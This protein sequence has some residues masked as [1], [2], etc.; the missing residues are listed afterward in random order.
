LLFSLTYASNPNLQWFGFAIVGDP[1]E[2]SPWTNLFIGSDEPSLAK[3]AELKISSL[4]PVETLFW[5]KNSEGRRTLKADWQNQWDSSK[6]FINGLIAKQHII[7]F[8]L[9]DEAV[10]SG[11]SFSELE[12]IANFVK[13]EYPNETLFYVESA[14]V[15]VQDKNSFDESVDYPYVP[16]AF[17]WFA[18]DAYPN[19]AS[20]ERVKQAY[21]EDI[22]PRMNLTRQHAFL[23]PPAY[24]TTGD[25]MISCGALD[26]T[27]VMIAWAKGFLEWAQS[28]TRISGMM[29]WY[30]QST[31]EPHFEIGARDMPAV[32]A[33]YRRVGNAIV[34]SSPQLFVNI[35][36][37]CAVLC[38]VVF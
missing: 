3:A 29:A 18:A 28:D 24:D 9:V 14:V 36:L 13:N 37:Y 6:P 26:C 32:A 17:D 25:K 8:Y 21:D 12:A 34:N 7:G 11:V 38:A 35:L 4:L 10:W 20:I 1:S 27:S 2:V 19:I 23:I 15:L 31:G 5:E 22:Y 30:W 33:E 16:E